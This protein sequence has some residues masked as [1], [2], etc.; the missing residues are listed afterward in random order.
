MIEKRLNILRQVFP[1][2][3]FQE[4]KDEFITWCPNKGDG[5][6]NGNHHKQKL[7]INLEK[8]V[9]D[10]WVC[11][12]SGFITRLIH[13]HFPSKLKTEYIK[14]LPDL[15]DQVEEPETRLELPGCAVFLL[16]ALDDYRAVNS[17]R[18]LREETGASDET[19]YFNKVM[20]CPRG[21]YAG[22]IL[23]PSFDKSGDL[24]FFQT[25]D[26]R[27]TDGMKYINSPTPIRN[28]VYN[29]IMIDWNSPIILVESIKSVLS[30][31]DIP[32]IVP[33]LGTRFT[34]RYKIFRDSVLNDLK[35]VYLAL[36]PEA[37]DKAYEIMNIYNS[38][39]IEAR[40]VNWSSK[41]QPDNIAT[42]DF[43]DNLFDY[44]LY[45]RKDFLYSKVEK[46]R[47]TL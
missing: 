38:F 5:G 14:T 30:H 26:V 13:D 40:L 4:A 8:N 1:D 23:F 6:C 24:N 7:Q 12:Y 47:K 33:I 46:I 25:R 39:G 31:Y 27:R 9:F 19:L 45:S 36:D 2:Y 44:S 28:V 43:V 20:F 41:V 21:D 11:G 15:K 37:K 34:K 35:V 16:D 17:L 32:N 42:E 22:R 3:I 29:E 18:W 10:C